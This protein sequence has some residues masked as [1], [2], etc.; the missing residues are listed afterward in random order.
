MEYLKP[1]QP[2][3]LL[4]IGALCVAASFAGCEFNCSFGVQPGVHGPGGD[5]PNI[6][7]VFVAPDVIS[8]DRESGEIFFTWV[9]PETTDGTVITGRLVAVD[10]PPLL[11]DTQYG[12][13]TLEAQAENDWGYFS[14]NPPNPD[15]GWSPGAYRFE[16]EID[17]ESFGSVS[18]TIAGALEIPD[19]A[20]WV[21][22]DIVA[23]LRTS[24]PGWT[25]VEGTPPTLRRYETPNG[26]GRFVEVGR[27]A[28]TEE[29][30]LAH[31]RQE[32]G[33]LVQPG[34][35]VRICGVDGT[36][37][38]LINP[39][40]NVHAMLTS[41][42][43]ANTLGYALTILDIPLDELREFNSAV[44]ENTVCNHVPMPQ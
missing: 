43:H 36:H 41:W 22:Q 17:G 26:V 18:Y 37:R 6:E 9:N 23:G 27:A 7:G 10:V 33:L 5:E 35:P 42:P 34:E 1:R 8:P 2:G 12:V 25:E 29:Q 16:A 13:N 24:L 11:K 21:Q 40:A 31:L 3:R 32:W 14:F 44:A 28:A 19:R 39:D 15:F 30:V 4:A 20:D 38:Y